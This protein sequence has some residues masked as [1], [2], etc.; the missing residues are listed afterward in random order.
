MLGPYK[1]SRVERV[2][3]HRWHRLPARRRREETLLALRVARDLSFELRGLAQ[4]GC[5]TLH[6]LSEAERSAFAV[7]SS[8]RLGVFAE[9]GSV[10][11]RVCVQLV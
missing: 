3:V 2:I 7:T 6:N 8:S 1:A 4:E 10:S 5:L 9:Q 11:V